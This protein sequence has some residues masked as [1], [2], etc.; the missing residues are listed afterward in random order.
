MSTR[1]SNLTVVL[2]FG[3]FILYRTIFPPEPDDAISNTLFNLSIEITGGIIL[4]GILQFLKN[5]KNLPLYFQ[6]QVLHRKKKIRISIAYLFRIKVDG[7]YLLIKSS[8]RNYFQ[9]VGGAFKTLPSSKRIFEKLNIE[10]DKLIET[11]KGIAKGDLR[12]FTKGVNV[13]DFIK[14]F[15]SKKD[16]ET[17]P[18]REFCEELLSTKILPKKPF[19]YIDYEYKNTVR[20]PLITLDSGDKGLFIHEIYD[21]IPNIEQE[22][23]LRELIEV[24]NSDKFIWADENLINRLGHNAG[25]K[26]Y[27]HEIALHTKWAHNLKWSKE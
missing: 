4:F 14:W 15:N 16:R 25:T 5:I 17:S 23:K 22:Q 2:I 24:K 8:R 26:E 21:L 10:S 20:S 27:E 11:E 1:F 6:T 18:W 3:G 19:R 7:K 13:I 9:P 12:V